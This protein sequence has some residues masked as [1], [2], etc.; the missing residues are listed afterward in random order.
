MF[1]LLTRCYVRGANHIYVGA[2]G[3][4][5]VWVVCFGFDGTR[6]TVSSNVF[7]NFCKAS[8]WRPCN[9]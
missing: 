6:S 1:A 2:V 7:P 8:P 4:D 3:V 9:V 5:D